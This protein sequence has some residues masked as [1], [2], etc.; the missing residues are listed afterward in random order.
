MAGGPE[1]SPGVIKINKDDAGML[2]RTLD[3]ATVRVF[4]EELG[5]IED[6]SLG[7]YKL[8]LGLVSVALALTAQ[9]YPAPFPE[10]WWVLVVCCTSYF[11]CSVALQYL[12]SF[13]QKDYVFFSHPSPCRLLEGDFQSHEALVHPCELTATPNHTLQ[14]PKRA[15]QVR[16][17]MP[18]Y[19]YNFTIGIGSKGSKESAEL[20][21]T[22]E[23]GAWFDEE[24]IFHE[25]V[26]KKDVIDLARQF[27]AK[28]H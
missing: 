6:D 4:A 7:T 8:I 9:F 15:I 3:D 28:K 10:N 11:V 27:W 14:L 24:G 17:H 16:T 23:V 19:S 21:L 2:K 1:A 25:E 22:K 26:F 5:F 20:E 18:K 13:K 12:A